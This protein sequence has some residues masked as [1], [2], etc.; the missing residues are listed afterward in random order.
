MKMAILDRVGPHLYG[1]RGFGGAG[2]RSF[3]P[4]AGVGGAIIMTLAPAVV[5]VLLYAALLR[6]TRHP[7]RIFTIIS[8]VAFVI[9]LIPGI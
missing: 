2:L 9:S 7:A 1:P 6:F 8:A 3:L 5:A 4:L